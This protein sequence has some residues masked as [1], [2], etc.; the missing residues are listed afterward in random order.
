MNTVTGK[1]LPARGKVA[2]K[3]D[4]VR[5]QTDAG[6]VYQDNTPKQYISGIV[7]SIGRPNI[8]N[9]GKEMSIACEEG[10]RVLVLKEQ[11]MWEI[12]EY[13]IANQEDVWAVIDKECK[14]G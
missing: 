1:F 8:N 6:I 9:K 10:D 11:G 4:E 12:G 2:I 14:I 13:L 3:Q 5:T 7:S